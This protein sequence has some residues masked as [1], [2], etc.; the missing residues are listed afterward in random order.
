M[1]IAYQTSAGPLRTDNQDAVGVFYNTKKA[2]LMMVADGVTSNPG[3][4]Q[5]SQ[6]VIRYLGA[7]WEI[8]HFDDLKQVQAWLVSQVH[9]ANQAVIETGRHQPGATQMATTLV[10]AVVIDHQLLIANAGDSKAYILHNHELSQLSFD[11]NLRNE[12][13]REQG[14]VYDDSLPQG[15]SLTRY[16]GVNDQVDLEFNYGNFFLEDVLFLTSDGLSKVLSDDDIVNIIEQSHSAAQR[17]EDLMAAAVKL[18]V[19]DN[20]TALIALDD[21]S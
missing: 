3:S 5:A 6:V 13:S 17:V 8:S 15:N 19:S 20:I 4:Q 16:L 2:P 9:L 21:E 10:L 18:N 12:L 14:K 7:H 1:Q 11:H